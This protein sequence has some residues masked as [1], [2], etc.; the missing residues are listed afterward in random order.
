MVISHSGKTPVFPPLEPLSDEP[1]LETERHLKQIMLLLLSLEWWW[2]ERP[3]APP[4]KR[5]RFYAAGNLTI[6]YSEDQK[7]NQDFR[8]PDFFVVLNTEYRERRS[9]AVWLEQGKY[10]NVIIEI[11]SDSTAEIDRVEKKKLYQNQFQTPEY[12]WFEPY[13][14]EF[15]GFRLQNRRYRA[16]RPNEAGW[17]WSEELELYVG[18]VDEKLRFLTAEGEVV[19]A[20]NEAALQTR[21]SLEMKNQQLELERQKTKRERQK[22]KRERQRAEEQEQR[23]EAERQRAET[24]KTELEKLRQRLVEQGISLDD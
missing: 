22:T 3:E 9:W 17:L 23:A 16:I 18:I 11:L 10:P 20:P 6:Y 12:F 19:P 2:R 5:E 7:R 24:L 4:E 15:Q 1:P 14:L 8:G 13:S 21:L